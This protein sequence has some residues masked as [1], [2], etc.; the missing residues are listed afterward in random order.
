MKSRAG[1]STADCTNLKPN[2][3]AFRLKTVTKDVDEDGD[4]AQ[5][6]LT[7]YKS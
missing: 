6:C 7:A 1:S 4:L 2:Q 3:K 5:A